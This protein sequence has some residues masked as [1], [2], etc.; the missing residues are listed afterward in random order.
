MVVHALSPSTG[1]QA[2]LYEFEASLFYV[3]SS[4]TVYIARSCLKKGKKNKQ[5][6][7]LKVLNEELLK[8]DKLSL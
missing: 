7:R 1:K 2:G 4:R 5:N 8:K 3:V 6:K